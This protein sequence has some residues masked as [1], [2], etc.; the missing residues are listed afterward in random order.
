[1]KMIEILLLIAIIAIAFT[2]LASASYHTSTF[3][4]SVV[5][6]NSPPVLSNET[7]EHELQGVSVST[8]EVSVNISD[9]GG[10]FNYTIEGSF[11]NDVSENVTTNGEKNA[12]I[13]SLE[14]LTTYTWYVNATDNIS[15]TNATYTFVTE[16]D[17]SIHYTSST[18]G[19]SV[20]ITEEGE[21]EMYFTGNES[22]ITSYGL[23]NISVYLDPVD[24]V[25]AWEFSI[26]FNESAMELTDIAEGDF[27]TK[28]GY[29][30]LFVDGN[31]SNDNGTILGIFS[32]IVGQGNTSEAGYLLNMTFRP[33]VAQ[34][35]SSIN[36]NA[37][38]EPPPGITNE[39]VYLNLSF[40]NATIT[41]DITDFPSNSSSSPVWKIGHTSVYDVSLNMI[42]GLT[43]L[44]NIA[45]NYKET[46]ANGWINADV[47][48]DGK[49]SLSDL[50]MVT[51]HYGED[52]T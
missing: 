2:S 9:N 41:L 3:G 10:F 26:D 14:P 47:N 40:T 42:V 34:S 5:I 4:G 29:S 33:L 30:T 35:T 22:T 43:D 15:W 25:K 7:P 23:F 38:T 12:T 39:T 31:T 49:V 48:D 36:F 21:N 19:G 45:T 50:T 6:Q 8:T 1:M 44:T 27:F 28:H 20:T 13:I 11:L 52:Y 17:G 32:L 51:T 37:S 46:G 16:N 24:Y 18:F